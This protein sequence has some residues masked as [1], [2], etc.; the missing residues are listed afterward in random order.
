MQVGCETLGG[1]GRASWALRSRTSPW[2]L[3]SVLDRSVES[4]MACLL[5][6][7]RFQLSV[8]AGSARALCCPGPW[9]LL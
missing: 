9:E 5:I 6:V 4:L 7:I 3:S 1:G 8:P 2:L